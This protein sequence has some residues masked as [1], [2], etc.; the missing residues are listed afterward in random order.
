MKLDITELIVRDN[1]YQEVVDM[2][3]LIDEIQAD[4]VFTEMV[5]DAFA[6]R[7]REMIS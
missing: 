4:S 3:L 7:Y 1:S 6:A 5:Y 2:F